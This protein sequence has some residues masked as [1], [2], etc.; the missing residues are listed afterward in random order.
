MKH[1]F[2]ILIFCLAG[3]LAQ[4]QTVTFTV[5]SLEVIQSSAV[6]RAFYDLDDVYV[7]YKA[8]NVTIYEASNNA[9][10]FSGDTSEVT[11][12]GA[13]HWAAA[14]VVLGTWYQNMT[15]TTGYKYWVPKRNVNMI[16]RTSNTS[17]KAVH[18]ITKKLLVETSID[19]LH[20]SGVSGASNKLTHLRGKYY[21]ESDR[22]RLSIATAP[23]IAAGAAAGSSPTVAVAG[24]GT[25]FKITLT[26]G[27][28]ALNSGVL[29]TVTLPVTYPNG[30]IATVTNGDSDSAAHAV[31][32]FTSTTGSTVVL[33]A[34][35]SAL[36]DA[37]Q[38]VWYVSVT[39]Y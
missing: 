35:A 37:T 23:T 24:T 21:L 38:Y 14:E 16:Y 9:T 36:S 17:V 27:T 1:L 32:V 6:T 28:T 2:S 29:A 22:D 34:T 8:G 5:T 13:S 30:V 15:T 4:A 19:S 12:P 33:N 7:R 26:T 18:N 39:G 25:A 3:M 20:I 10:L 11:V 31:R